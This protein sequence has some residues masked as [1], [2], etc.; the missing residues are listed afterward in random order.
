VIG[1]Q[2]K[3]LFGLGNP[4]YNDKSR[5]PGSVFCMVQYSMKFSSKVTDVCR[6]LKDVVTGSLLWCISF[7]S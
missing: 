5:L 1:S 6:R 7:E 4:C 3:S 2:N